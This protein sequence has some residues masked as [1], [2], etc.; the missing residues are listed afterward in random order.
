MSGSEGKASLFPFLLTVQKR[1]IGEGP[2]QV[3]QSSVLA[4]NPPASNA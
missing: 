2:I 4:P 3:Q 1:E